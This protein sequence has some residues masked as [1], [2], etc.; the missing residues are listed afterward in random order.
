[1][2]CVVTLRSLCRAD[3]PSRGVVPN[4]MCLECDRKTWTVRRPWP[5]VGCCAMRGVCV[6]VC[7]CLYAFLD[8]SYVGFVIGHCAVK[9]AH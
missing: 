9:L 6:C 4:V 1:M 8:L 5:T 3:H 2:F 7:V